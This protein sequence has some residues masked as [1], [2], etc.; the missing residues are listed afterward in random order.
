MKKGQSTASLGMVNDF[1]G[2]ERD[3]GLATVIDIEGKYVKVKAVPKLGKKFKTF[4]LM[5]TPEIEEKFE[6]GGINVEGGGC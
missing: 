1:T 6:A 5:I 4:W 3:Y 2:K